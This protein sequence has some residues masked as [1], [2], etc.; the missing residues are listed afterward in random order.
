MTVLPMAVKS[1]P[2]VYKYY[3]EGYSI[4]I[5]SYMHHKLDVCDV[6]EE[7]YVQTNPF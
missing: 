3:S 6:L 5:L 1:P 4:E 7:V 2:N